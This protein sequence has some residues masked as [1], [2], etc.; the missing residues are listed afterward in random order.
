MTP[1]G[2][3][4]PCRPKAMRRGVIWRA[5]FRCRLPVVSGWLR[6]MNLLALL[7]TGAVQIVQPDSAQVGGGL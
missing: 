3:K 1:C 5:V 6:A 7:D 2:L 4:N